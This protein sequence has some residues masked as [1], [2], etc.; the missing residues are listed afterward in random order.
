MYINIRIKIYN[1]HHNP[2]AEFNSDNPEWLQ[3]NMTVIQASKYL[4]VTPDTIY[5]AINKGHLVKGYR[6]EDINAQ[7]RKQIEELITK[8]TQQ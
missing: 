2:L 1:P 8:T 7:R 3:T 5:K 4:H 6:I